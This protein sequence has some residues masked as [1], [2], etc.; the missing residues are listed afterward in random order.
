MPQF[1]LK[2]RWGGFLSKIT[3]ITL[4]SA[5]DHHAW[6]I[7]CVHVQGRRVMRV[8]VGKPTCILI[9]CSIFRDP[10]R[11]VDGREH[12]TQD[13]GRDQVERASRSGSGVVSPCL[14][15]LLCVCVEQYTVCA[16]LLWL[17]RKVNPCLGG[18]RSHTQ[19]LPQACTWEAT[20]VGWGA[21]LARPAEG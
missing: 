19:G 20:Q 4:K 5:M 16:P 13:R 1:V 9:A 10:R 15:V 21:R 18:T 17:V 6:H 2:I 8:P 14:C 3:I 11:H 12:Q 7:F